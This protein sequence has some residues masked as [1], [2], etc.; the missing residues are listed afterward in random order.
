MVNVGVGRSR[1]NACCGSPT[2][3]LAGAHYLAMKMTK[4][5]APKYA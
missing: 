1:L 2:S 4:P 5:V 3:S